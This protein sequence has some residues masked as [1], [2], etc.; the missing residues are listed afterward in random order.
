VITDWAVPAGCEPSRA[1]AEGELRRALWT[2][3]ELRALAARLAARGPEALAEVAPARRTTAW[4]DAVAALLD[5][6]SAERRALAPGLARSARLSRPGLDAALAV[7]VGGTGPEAAAAIAGRLSAAARRELAGVVLASNV[8]GLAVQSVLPALLLGR[9]LLVKSSVREPLFAPALV[10]ALARR[11]PV[12]ADA[13]AAV[14]W[15]GHDEALAA[16][17]FTPCARLL[18]YGGAGA[19]AALTAR[20]GDRLIAFGPRASVAL[21]SPG[22]D[23]ASTAAGLARD[24]ALLDQRGCLSV[25]AVWIDAG[26]ERELARHLAAALARLAVELPAGPLDAAAAAQAHQLRAEAELRGALIGE[27]PLAAGSVLLAATPEFRPVP[28]LRC[29]RVHAVPTLDAALAALSPWR[30]RLQGAALAG[31]EATT[32]AGEIAA[33]LGLART[34]PAGELQHARAG[35]ASGGIDPLVALG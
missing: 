12:L 8:P 9:P 3:D 31:D 7:V 11:E 14:A 17:A 10:A 28:G 25:Q 5:P 15:P 2:A 4:N 26:R 16:A 21:V 19:V 24:V 20:F 33:R 1:V 32:R 22:A 35:W 6:A 30:G 13:F 34:A 29:V 23:L 18:A 27:L